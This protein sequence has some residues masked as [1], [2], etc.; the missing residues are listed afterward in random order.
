MTNRNNNSNINLEDMNS[1]LASNASLITNEVLGPEVY[2]TELL[3]PAKAIED[4][5]DVPE[6]DETSVQEII[7]KLPNKNSTGF[8]SISTKMLKI[9]SNLI[10]IHVVA[11]INLVISSTIYPSNEKIK[12]C[13]HL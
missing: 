4:N 5:L 2:S 9:S 12:N 7:N 8:D 13:S 11:L 10:S 3:E 6:I 1:F